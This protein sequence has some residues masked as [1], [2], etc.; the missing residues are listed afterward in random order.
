MLKLL[1]F[2]F[3]K[4]LITTLTCSVQIPFGVFLPVFDSGAALGRALSYIVPYIGGIGHPCMYA[5]I[6]GA[7]LISSSTHALSVIIIIYE[8]TGK[9]LYLI[10]MTLSVIISY[11]IAKTYELNI[12]DV[13]IQS[14]NIP[15]LPAIRKET[16][17]KHSAKDIMEKT[18]YLTLS[19]TIKNLKDC[20]FYEDRIK[21]PI[22]DRQ[23]YIISETSA[24]RIKKY[25]DYCIEN[26]TYGCTADIKQEVSK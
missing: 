17:Y 7:G 13:S 23:R 5:V 25:L 15:F 6:G 21:I 11:Q 8:V 3:V 1:S 14:R 22:V 18:V 24:R 26:F 9:I 16:L 19:S 2:S 12:Y 4:F 20:A 10:P